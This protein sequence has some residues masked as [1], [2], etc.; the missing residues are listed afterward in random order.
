MTFLAPLWH[1][2]GLLAPALVVASLLW[3]GLR[4]RPA[5]VVVRSPAMQFGVLALTGVL[6]LL[7]G[8]AYFGRDGKMATYAA[9]VLAQGTATWW[10]RGR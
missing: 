2:A 7:I 9:L 10:M 6:V 1:L 4:L 8:L 5:R 3:L